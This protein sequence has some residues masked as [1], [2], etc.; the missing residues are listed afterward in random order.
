MKKEIREIFKVK[1]LSKEMK[2]ALKYI[3]IKKS[4]KVF[5][6]GLLYTKPYDYVVKDNNI[7]F[8]FTLFNALIIN[9]FY[10]Y[11]K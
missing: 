7:I 6:N 4:E 10:D 9:I 1:K 11:E 3:P 5:I 8:K 2:I